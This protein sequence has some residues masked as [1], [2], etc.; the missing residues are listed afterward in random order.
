[1]SGVGT[2]PPAPP[3]PA[4]LPPESSLSPPPSPAAFPPETSLSPIAPEVAPPAPLAEH[5]PAPAPTNVDALIARIKAYD[6]KVDT[7]VVARAFALAAKAHGTQKRDNG[8]PYII[9]PVAVAEIL[10]GYKLDVG[11]IATALM[12]DVIEDTGISRA[13]RQAEHFQF[14]ATEPGPPQ[15]V[16]G[17]QHGGGIG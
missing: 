5:L 10:A 1:M 2:S 15:V 6:P 14:A 13:E 11:S 8:D 3:S 7:S 12:H 4:V 9:H 17:K 16:E